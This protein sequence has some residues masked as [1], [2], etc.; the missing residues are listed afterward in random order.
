MDSLRRHVTEITACLTSMH[1]RIKSNKEEFR[2]IHQMVININQVQSSQQLWLDVGGSLFHISEQSAQSEPSSVLAILTQ[3]A[4]ACE[5]DDRGYHFIDRDPTLFPLL[6]HHLRLTAS[7]C[8]AEEHIETRP[9]NEPSPSPASAIH[10]NFLR[11]VRYYGIEKLRSGGIFVVAQFGP[12]LAFT[13]LTRCSTDHSRW[14]RLLDHKL[15]AL[16]SHWGCLDGR[17]V[18][19]EVAEEGLVIKCWYTDISRMVHEG[20]NTWTSISL[21]GPQVL[22]TSRSHYGT[23]DMINTDCGCQMVIIVRT[24]VWFCELTSLNQK[25][26]WLRLPDLP[27][28]HSLYSRPF[29]FRS[30]S[31]IC[32]IGDV[33][34]VAGGSEHVNIPGMGHHWKASD[35][36]VGIAHGDAE[37]HELSPMHRSRR[38]ACGVCFNNSLIVVGG[39]VGCAWGDDYDVLGSAEMYSPSLHTWIELPVLHEARTNAHAV[40]VGNSVWV[41]G[42]NN[43]RNDEIFSVERWQ[44][45]CT[46]WEILPMVTSQVDFL[47]YTHIHG[48]ASGVMLY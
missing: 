23:M 39:D 24:K 26:E 45:G 22:N 6:L 19:L 14:W 7:Q 33:L 42:G 20:H 11:E 37:W 16:C 8:V 18:A 47:T 13:D 43:L 28:P 34:I 35:R 30:T 27:H 32:R 2:K 48:V 5:A 31:V 1:A 46:N 41:L 9:S 4:F 21:D 40:V 3:G 15:D 10:G 44:P 17:L 12:R 25:P 38:N 36:V 29:Y